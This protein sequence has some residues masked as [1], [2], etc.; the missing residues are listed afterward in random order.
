MLVTQDG[1]FLGVPRRKAGGRRG[2][3]GD[4]GPGDARGG[5]RRR[6]G[7]D[8]AGLLAWCT[9]LAG[10]EAGLVLVRALWVAE[11]TLQPWRPQHETTGQDAGAS[12][13]SPGHGAQGKRAHL[14]QGG[15]ARPSPRGERREQVRTAG[16]SHDG[17][18]ARGLESPRGGEPRREPDAVPDDGA[19]ARAAIAGGGAGLHG[20]E[21]CGQRG[22]QRGPLRG[23]AAGGA[24]VRLARGGALLRVH[25]DAPIGTAG[26]E[27]GAAADVAR[28]RVLL[29]THAG[30]LAGLRHRH[31]RRAQP[32]LAHVL[33][34]V[35]GPVRHARRV[36]GGVAG[37]AD[38]GGEPPAPDRG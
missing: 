17:S 12:G 15:S 6:G 5:L 38:W 13:C 29:R 20:L 32:A 36:D 22:E 31:R 7:C 33:A 11:V 26:L 2:L 21:R 28:E 35:H 14:P 16:P 3:A 30:R 37:G 25:G 34:G 1:D 10:F 18:D 24:A 27:R 8:A 19:D 9:C 4:A 23:A